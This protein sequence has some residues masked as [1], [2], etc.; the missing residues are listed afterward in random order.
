MDKFR[1]NDNKFATT[2][3]TH[4]KYAKERDEQAWVSNQQPN[5]QQKP[6]RYRKQQA[7]E[8]T[9]ERKERTEYPT[10]QVP[11]TLQ[12]TIIPNNAK[13][14][15]KRQRGAE[16]EKEND[17]KLATTTTTM[18]SR[19]AKER[20]EQA[21]VSNQQPNHQQIP[22]THH[23]KK[24]KDRVSPTQQTTEKW[25][26]NMGGKNKDRTTVFLIVDSALVIKMRNVRNS[27]W[28]DSFILND[29][30]FGCNATV[31]LRNS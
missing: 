7:D 5:Q 19:F 2:T 30:T 31:I 1:E 17:N 22:I 29:E 12:P 6:P 13:E 26:H 16:T 4:S 14:V 24:G 28:S 21:W 9:T 8:G 11:C 18:H 23:G 25:S 3:T 20:D 27:K 15:R 10:K